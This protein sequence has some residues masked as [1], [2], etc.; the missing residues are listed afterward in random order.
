[1]SVQVA[2]DGTVT[3]DA[4]PIA[5]NVKDD[6]KI[7]IINNN[8]FK[9]SDE[10]DNSYQNYDHDSDCDNLAHCRSDPANDNDNDDDD[11][12]DVDVD[13]RFVVSNNT[14]RGQSDNGFDNVA[15]DGD[16]NVDDQHG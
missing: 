15:V 6:D 5:D 12:V 2:D 11:D 10:G 1:M 14:D 3:L 9:D 16:V 7:D 8:D 4:D 13:N